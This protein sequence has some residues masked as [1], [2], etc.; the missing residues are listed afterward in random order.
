MPRKKP[1]PGSEPQRL[2]KVLAH[3]GIASRRASEALIQEGRVSVNGRVV[4]ELGTKVDPNRDIINVDGRPVS[5]RASH[6]T[7]IMLNKPRQVLS[8][9]RDERGRKTVMDLVDCPE[10][11]YPVGRLDFLSEGLMLLTNDGD[12]TKRLTHPKH[13][14]EK[15]YQA[16]VAGNPSLVSLNQWRRGGIEVE[17]EPVGPAKVEVMKVEGENTWLKVVL[18]EGRK[19]Q[20]REVASALGHPVRTLIRVRLGPLRL[21]NIKPGQW[22]YLNAR[23]IQRLKEAANS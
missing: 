19:R 21:G 11:V 8:S 3:A 5:K 22:R 6:F 20:I 16:L 12:L 10:R 17:G 15:E 7:Y 4:T 13:Q 18:T 14:V 1:E 9:A 23:E 2:Q